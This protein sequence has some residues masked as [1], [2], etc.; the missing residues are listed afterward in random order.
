MERSNSEI[1]G[2]VDRLEP[3]PRWLPCRLSTVLLRLAHR[4]CNQPRQDGGSDRQNDSDGYLDPDGGL[5]GDGHDEHQDDDPERR[6]EGDQ[7]AH[8]PPDYI[9]VTG[10]LRRLFRLTHKTHLLEDEDDAPIILL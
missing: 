6:R 8:S 10:W 9:R 5:K 3:G 1:V 4:R 7:A 2:I